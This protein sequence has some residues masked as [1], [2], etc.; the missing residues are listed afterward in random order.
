MYLVFI[1]E[2][3]NT[4]FNFRDE[5][6]PYHYIGGVIVRYNRCLQLQDAIEDIAINIYGRHPLPENFEF[7]GSWLFSGNR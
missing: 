6:Q 5:D 7:K 3:G 1:D 4:G 2:S